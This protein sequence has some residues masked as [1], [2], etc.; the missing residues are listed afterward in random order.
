MRWRKMKDET[1]PR[2]SNAVLAIN[3]KGAALV[4]YDPSKG[5][6]WVVQHLPGRGETISDTLGQFHSWCDINEWHRHTNIG[7][8]PAYYGLES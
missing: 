2:Y 4:W 1:P 5:A 6:T 8:N 7:L 3:N